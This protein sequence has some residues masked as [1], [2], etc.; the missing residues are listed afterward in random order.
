MSDP[1]STEAPHALREYYRV[2]TAGPAEYGDG[3]PLRPL[4]T[5]HL[6]FTGS[7]AGHHPDATDAFLVGV[8]GFI[9]SV[10]SLRVVAEVHQPG[11]SAVLYDADLPGGTVRFAE[12]FTFD[13][14]R[15]ASIR[16][17]YDGPDYL[18]KGGH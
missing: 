9:E 3:A 10:R 2:L 12:F 7:L 13:A 15:I 16:L 5:D 14:D 6:D 4:L 17:H 18:A 1:L 11:A 8:A